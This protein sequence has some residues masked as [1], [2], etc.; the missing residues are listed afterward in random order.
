[1]TIREMIFAAPDMLLLRAEDNPKENLRTAYELAR[2]FDKV[3]N[4]TKDGADAMF[5]RTGAFLWAY[6]D[7]LGTILNDF[8]SR[9][10]MVGGATAAAT[11][12]DIS[13]LTKPDAL[14]LFNIVFAIREVETFK[15]DLI[16]EMIAWAAR[17]TKA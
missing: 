4:G 13:H 12:G 9:T 14:E 15:R 1:M 5:K 10:G 6:A 11:L 8:Y 7:A 2:T 16:S 17:G 3:P